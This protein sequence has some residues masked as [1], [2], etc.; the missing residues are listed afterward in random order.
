MSLVLSTDEIVEK[1]HEAG[2]R[3]AAR[4]ETQLTREIAEQFY[5]DQKGTEHFDDLV[6][7]MIR[8]PMLCQEFILPLPKRIIFLVGIYLLVLSVYRQS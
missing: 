1:I 5:A 8:W 6:E 4:K 7:H 2:F 3:I